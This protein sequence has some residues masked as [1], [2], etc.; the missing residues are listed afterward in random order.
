MDNV[1]R[2]WDD[3][4]LFLWLDVFGCWPKPRWKNRQIRVAQLCF[5]KSVTTK[6]HDT[7]LSKVHV[8]LFFE[9]F[10]IKYYEYYVTNLLIWN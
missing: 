8:K 6:N 9:S 5:S 10:S 2:R 7:T 1:I 4:I 3:D